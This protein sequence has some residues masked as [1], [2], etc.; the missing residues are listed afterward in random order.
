M[1]FKS[2]HILGTKSSFTWKYSAEALCV[3]GSIDF[4][5]H[6][7]APKSGLR[8]N[9]FDILLTI[10]MSFTVCALKGDHRGITPSINSKMNFNEFNAYNS[11]QIWE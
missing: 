5:N 10:N 8:Y 6:T 4:W 3:T 2:N 1:I 11:S 7:N 9:E